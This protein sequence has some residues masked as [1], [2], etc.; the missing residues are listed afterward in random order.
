MT[1]IVL[2]LA[3]ACSSPDKKT[4]K[5]RHELSSWAGAGAVLSHGWSQGK[6]ARP[7]VRSTLTVASDSLKGLADP[8]EGD[9]KA[10]AQLFRVTQLFDGLSHAVANDD[11]P[12][13]G[14]LAP[15]F[16]AISRALQKK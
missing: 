10:K 11:R 5:A 12:A 3:L 7:Y 4:E 15:E 1:P 9:E 16:A 2:V 8:L 6:L 14:P 13:A